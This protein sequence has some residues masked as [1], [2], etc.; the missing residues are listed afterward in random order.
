MEPPL[1][2]RMRYL[3]KDSDKLTTVQ[4]PF[5]LIDARESTQLLYSRPI[6]RIT[7]FACPVRT[8]S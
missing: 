6:S 4:F 8:D 1:T 7:R 3:F 5:F 2:V